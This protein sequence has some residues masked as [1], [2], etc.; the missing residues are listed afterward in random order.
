MAKTLRITV[1]PF[2]GGG[3]EY[4]VGGFTAFGFATREAARSAAEAF[5]TELEAS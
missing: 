1:K 5:R 3:F 4:S 2:I